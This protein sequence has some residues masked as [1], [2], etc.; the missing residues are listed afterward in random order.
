MAVRLTGPVHEVEVQQFRS[1]LR[2]RRAWAV[3]GV[4]RHES[5]DLASLDAM[6]RELA[7]LTWHYDGELAGWQVT[8]S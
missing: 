4:W 5:L 7:E 8:G 3:T 2:R 6:T 1:G